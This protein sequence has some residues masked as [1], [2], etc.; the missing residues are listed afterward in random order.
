[1]TKAYWAKLWNSTSLRLLLLFRAWTFDPK[2]SLHWPWPC[3]FFVFACDYL[4]VT[5]KSTTNICSIVLVCLF[6]IWTLFLPVLLN[7]WTV[8]RLSR[9]KLLR[10]CIGAH[11]AV[12][13]HQPT[14]VPWLGAAK[15]LAPLATYC[16]YGHTNAMLVEKAKR[17]HEPQLGE[18]RFWSCWICWSFPRSPAPSAV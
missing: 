10:L 5:V 11:D 12:S 3:L 16:G 13:G 2:V 7:P 18:I 8:Q 4:I 17:P 14:L 1:M 9:D 6:T 15:S